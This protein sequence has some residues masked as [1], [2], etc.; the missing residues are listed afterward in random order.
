MLLV[1]VAVVEVQLIRQHRHQLYD[2]FWRHTAQPR[3]GDLEKSW[4]GGFLKGY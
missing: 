3:E 4:M 1:F 2:Q